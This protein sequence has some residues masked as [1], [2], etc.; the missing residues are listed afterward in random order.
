MPKGKVLITGG[1]GYIGAHTAV[2][3]FEAGYE[4]LVLDNFSNTLPSAIDA[5]RQ[6]TFN[7]LKVY[8]T[9]CCDYQ[10]LEEVYLNE[11]PVGVIHFA[12]FKA[13][14]ESVR[15]PLKYYKNNLM[16]L[17][18]VLELS[19]KH[20]IKN[21]VFSSSCTVYG[22]PEHLPVHEGSPILPAESPYGNTKQIGEEMVRD[23]VQS[24]APLAAISL[25]YFNPVGAH[26]SSKLGELPLG[27]P[28]NLV[29]FI[30]QTVAGWRDQL[31][32]FGD[33]YPT[34][35]GTCIRDYIHVC[36]LAE[37]HV[38]AIKTLEKA[39]DSYSGVDY[40]NIGTGRGH[41]VLEV[42][43]A[44]EDTTGHKLNYQIGPR[45]PGDVTAVFADTT[46][47]K[48]ALGWSPK[49]SMEEA[50]VHAW[51]WQKTLKK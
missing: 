14:G 28:N 35:D 43:H 42:I 8:E 24:G 40:I 2:A 39:E 45:R 51:N 50:L 44:F 48:K 18:N 6:L 20:S 22:Q 36:D 25:R 16:S 17:A 33:D 4:P 49:Y 3:L 30:T 23:A 19:V 47:S 27:T 5:I 12:A 1:A 38:A 10:A 34:P 46:K 11:K 32:V 15:L 41:S 37:A 9:D 7:G 26:P 21:L 29:P 31:T 13:V